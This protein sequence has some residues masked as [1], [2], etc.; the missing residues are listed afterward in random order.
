M[1]IHTP[2]TLFSFV[3]CLMAVF[4]YAQKSKY[5]YYN[6]SIA[7]VETQKDAYYQ[8]DLSAITYVDDTT[9]VATLYS[10]RNDTLK[11]AKATFYDARLQILHGDYTQFDAKTRQ[12]HV[13]GKYKKGKPEGLWNWLLTDS[14]HHICSYREG[15]EQGEK[16]IYHTKSNKIACKM[17]YVEGKIEGNAN[18][19]DSNGNCT[20]ILNYKNGQR[21]GAYEDK[22]SE[23]LKTV[24]KGMYNDSLRVG[25]W[26]Y[27]YKSGQVSAKGVYKANLKDGEWLYYYE[28]GQAS[29]HET[30]TEGKMTA[31]KLFNEK[32]VQEYD[33]NYEAEA[34]P[35]FV[36]GGE[37]GLM[38]YLVKNV[39]YPKACRRE[40][41]EGKLFI[42]FVVDKDGSIIDANVLRSPHALMSVEAMRVVTGMP[43]WTPGK[44]HNIAVKVRYTLPIQFKLD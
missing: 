7:V 22:Y 21:H 24:V 3:F 23:N 16:I 34:K 31:Y 1:H 18:Y 20:L 28:N 26:S 30:Y 5:V 25:A 17:H 8:A 13:A 2:K 32:G 27:F 42:T 14:T 10:V 41:I 15:K 39:K 19:F 4:S 12:L 29:A 40:S 33:E 43:K 38:Q 37:A 44:Q 36:D 11:R 6:E 9:W 35:Q